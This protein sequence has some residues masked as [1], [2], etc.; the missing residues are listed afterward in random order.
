[1]SSRSAKARR[2]IEEAMMNSSRES[3][4]SLGIYVVAA[5]GALLIMVILV[6]LVRR[7]TTPAPL[8]SARATERKTAL[9]DLRG[10]EH[11][12][13]TEIDWQDK[14]KNLVRLPIQTAMNLTVERMKDAEAF[15]KDLIARVQKATAAP[16]AEPAKPSA[17]E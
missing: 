1:M 16:P 2:N 12:Q 9:V 3:K 4:T 11:K 13:L 17:F 6:G 7:Y 14:T 5:L 10:A 8:N 15:R